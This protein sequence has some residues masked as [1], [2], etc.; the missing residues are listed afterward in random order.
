MNKK[1]DSKRQKNHKIDSRTNGIHIDSSE[2]SL[3]QSSLE[4]FEQDRNDR[5]NDDESG[6]DLSGDEFQ[7]VD[8]Q[9]E[10]EENCYNGSYLREV[11]DGMVA[12]VEV[13]SVF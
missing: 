4:E 12:D 6:V 5:R 2:G 9:I 7:I 3:F 1:S 11:A 10:A 13:L 8:G